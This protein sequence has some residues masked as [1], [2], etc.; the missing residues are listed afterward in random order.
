MLART[1]SQD[2][3]LI[4]DDDPDVAAFVAEVARTCDFEATVTSRAEEFRERHRAWQPTHVMLDL[5]MPETDGVELIRFLAAEGSRAQVVLMSGFDAR[6]LES[7]RRLGTERGLS[8][9]AV[10]TKPMGVAELR[11]TLNRLKSVG[12]VIDGT[13]LALAIDKGELVLTYQPKIELASHR[14]AGFEALVRWMH[15]TRGMLSPAV[16]IPLAERTDMIKRV[17][18]EVARIALSQ[19]RVWRDEGLEV[20][21]AINVSGK[22][23]SEVRFADD[24]SGLC[25]E[26][27]VKPKWLTLELTETAAAANAVDAMDILARLRLM[28]FHISIDDFGTGYSSMKQLQR[29]PFSE[30]KVDMEFVRECAVSKDAR[31]IVKTIIDLAHNLGLRAVAEGVEDEKTLAIL[32]EF[33]CDLAQGYFISRP[34]AVEQVRAW[35]TTWANAHSGVPAQRGEV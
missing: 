3:L 15:P 28:G 12:E 19:L 25:A 6:V 27:G 24:L 13:A 5:H 2:R 11:E 23:L 33:G 29:L 18:R 17:T 8:M 20:A 31:T 1:M 10:V 7:V 26:L 14:V 30:L 4:I 22:D 35:L 34:L 32:S 21:V 9:A 16:F